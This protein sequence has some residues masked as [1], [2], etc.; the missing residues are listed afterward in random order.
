[1]PQKTYIPQAVDEA[2]RLSRYFGRWQAKM[3]IGATSQQ[4]T[5]LTNLAACIVTFLQEWTK[6]PPN[7]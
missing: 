3:M 2:Q 4:I 1:M 5:A 6:P 7:P